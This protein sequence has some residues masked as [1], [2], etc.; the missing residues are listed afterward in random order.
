MEIW[1]K[2]M[3]LSIGMQII[4]HEET[5]GG[6][7]VLQIDRC[8]TDAGGSVWRIALRAGVTSEHRPQIGS[9]TSEEHFL[10]I[11]AIPGPQWH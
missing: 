8:Q 11:A 6:G 10:E 1:N 3:V 7:E 2:W 5:V 9:E 4:Q